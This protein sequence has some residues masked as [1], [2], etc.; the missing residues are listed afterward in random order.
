MDPHRD[1]AP[2][3][4]AHLGRPAY[5]CRPAHPGR[6]ECTGPS[7]SPP[8]GRG[9]GPG[10]APGPGAGPDRGAAPGSREQSRPA[11]APGADGSVELDRAR[12]LGLLAGARV[13]R[14]VY[15][16][17]ALPAVLPTGFR[18]DADGRIR[19]AVAAG[20]EVVRAVAGAVVAFEADEVDGTDGSGWC[21]TVLG[22][23]A[24]QPG[25]PG[26]SVQPGEL[27]GPGE[28]AEPGGP[29]TEPPAE[30]GRSSVGPPTTQAE[31]AGPVAGRRPPGDTLV[32]ITAELVSGRRFGRSAG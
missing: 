6:T 2:A 28:L 26:E 8:G 1:A 32:V 13:G 7:A 10:A 29:R 18:L 4:Q 23:A 11:P 5:P 17:G 27:A 16:V 12:A 31:P 24:V 19:L 25:E 14:L 3:H 21:V 30:Q 20:S 9:P 22:R 15:T